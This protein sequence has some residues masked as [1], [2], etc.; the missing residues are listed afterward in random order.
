MPVARFG[1]KNGTVV[2]LRESDDLLAVRS[3]SGRS[4]RGELIP[5]P[6]TAALKDMDLVA[7]FTDAGVEV[8]RR[9]KGKDLEEAKVSLR[10]GADTR[11]AGRVLVTETSDDPVIY[12]E[13]IFVKFR[14]DLDRDRCEAILRDAGLAVKRELPFAT[15]AY[16]AAAAEGTGQRVFAIAEALLK[17][18]EVELC[19][20]ELIRRRV[21]KAIFPQQWHLQTTVIGGQSINAH[22]NVAAAHALTRGRGAVIA[23]IDDGVD[24]DHQE[25]G[26]AGK[27]VAPRDAT[28]QTN[29]PRPKINNPNPFLA[30]SHGTAC[31]GVACAGGLL[32]ASGVAPDATLMPVRLSSGLGSIREAEAFD[33]A[34]DHGAD[35]ISCSWG[36]ADG[37]W[38]NPNDP[39]HNE[40]VP[41][42]D[43]TRLAIKRAV[44]SGR[45]GKGCVVFFAA[46][47]GNESVD[48]DG[49]ASNENVLAV[50]A[51]NDRGKRS[52]YSDFGNAVFCSFPSS[53]SGF[54]EENHPEPLTLGIWT[55]DRSGTNGY[56]RGGAHPEEGADA[57]GLFTS[58]FGGT[59]SAAPGAAGVAALVIAA[60]PALRGDQ[61]KDI[62][63][64]S[65][66][67]IDPTGGQYNA[68]GRSTKYGFGRLNAETA[69]KLA[70]PVRPTNAVSVSR[71]LNEPI[72]DF[73][74]A[75]AALSVN[76]TSVVN[77]VRV[78]VE[79]D[80]TF[81]GD[82]VIR[83]LGPA[84][85]HVPAVVLHDR[86]GG[87]TRNIR[88]VYD[89][90]NLPALARFRGKS[91]KGSWTLEVKDTAA[92]DQGRLLRFGLEF[93]LEPEPRAVPKRRAPR[94]KKASGSKA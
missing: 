63:R 20:P 67:R 1:G 50:A 39:I 17:H 65:C 54:P 14:D 57:A 24:V 32:G 51:C 92:R 61:V 69:V 64:R 21:P 15:N 87:R 25:F 94:P 49:Y 56:N 52:V 66:D 9:R 84:E 28:L 86:A 7:A 74:T 30:D 11:F 82:L 3:L 6:E 13:N 29:D 91:P 16:F 22:A 4:L 26:A 46:G 59:S 60:N 43:A 81:I 2:K 90:M 79:L 8:Y 77:D 36:P 12:T 80:H 72:L 75:Q 41:I 85:L 71:D 33:W 35:V 62:L 38:F 70:V 10:A 42:S 76:E 88:R 18:D 45:S 78:A 34:I 5:R 93:D 27:I 83:L 23:I 47:N 73:A 53:D 48:N 68:Q 31:A 55:T 58:S 37:E 40:V 44:E 89:A 19:H